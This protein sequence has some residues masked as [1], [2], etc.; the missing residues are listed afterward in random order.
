MNSRFTDVVAIF[1]HAY[2]TETPVVIDCCTYMVTWDSEDEMY[3]FK[4]RF[5]GHFALNVDEVEGWKEDGHEI[6]YNA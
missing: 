1:D 6:V 2:L 3:R 4:D 5:G